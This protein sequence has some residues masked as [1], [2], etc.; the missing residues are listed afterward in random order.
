MSVKR[1]QR[2]IDA[3]EFAEWMAA[4]SVEPWGEERADLRAG[5]IASTTANVTAGNKTKPGDFMPDFHSEPRRVQTAEEMA[6]ALNLFRDLVQRK[7]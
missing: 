5:I 2:E 4:Y 1:A 6:A 3:R 7:Q